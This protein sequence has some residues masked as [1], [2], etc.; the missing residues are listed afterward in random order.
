ME[1]RDHLLNAEHIGASWRIR[2]NYPCAAAMRPCVK[3]FRPLVVV[4]IVD[5]C[6]V[7]RNEGVPKIIV[8]NTVNLFLTAISILLSSNRNRFRVLFDRMASVYLI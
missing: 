5:N 3:S 2:L 6:G 4:S 7:Y 8:N 1:L